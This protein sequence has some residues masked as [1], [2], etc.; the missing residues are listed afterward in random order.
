MPETFE[1]HFAK[2]EEEPKSPEK[3]K[4]EQAL[5]LAK[6]IKEME[7]KMKTEGKTIAGYEKIIELTKKIKEIFEEE[8]RDYE[9]EAKRI[10]TNLEKALEEGAKKNYVAVGLAGVGTKE[11]MELRERLLKE[12]ASKNYVAEGLVGVNTEEAEK[13][14]RKHFGDDPD[15]FAQSYSTGWSE[16]NGVICRYGYEK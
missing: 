9:A 11:S 16:Y 10:V 2:K 13:F 7:E 3:I 5:K 14:R 8:E 15:L 12:G 6:E 1:K 4:E